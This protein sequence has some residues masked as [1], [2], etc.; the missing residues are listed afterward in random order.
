MSTKGMKRDVPEQLAGLLEPIDSIHPCPRNPRTGHAVEAIARSIRDFGWHAP[1]VARADG[2]I[3]IG[4]GRLEAA[5][6]LGLSS[7][8]VLRVDDTKA[9]AIARMV[10]DNRLTELSGWDVAE[11][12]ALIGDSPDLAAFSA[13][14]DLESIL[15]GLPDVG[16][17]GD[18]DDGSCVD[19]EPQVSIA[20]ELCEK[21]GV[22]T[23]QMWALGEHRIVCGDC[24]DASVVAQ[25]MAG[26]VADLVVT[27]PPY[28]VSYADK[29][30]FLNSIDEGN[31][32]QTK[33]EGDHKTPDEMLSFW[34]DVWKTTKPH[35]ADHCSYYMTGPQGGDLLLLLL[36]SLREAGWTLKHMLIWAKNNHVLGR[37]D[38]NYKHEPIL[39]GWMKKHRWYGDGSQTSLWEV[40]RPNVAKE[41]PTMKPVALF[42]CAVANSSA[43]GDLVFEPFS[44]SGTTIIACEQ[45]GRKC[46]A[47]EISPGY[48]AVAIQRWADATGGEPRLLD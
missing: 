26:G 13:D 38:Y 43:P 18:G 32:V 19:A 28:G 1:I 31:R 14:L 45:L 39:Y 35:L 47:I 6:L 12:E 11:L 40:P 33:I 46:R 10:A 25:V 7:V 23:G 37:C 34:T 48:V 22:K 16:D 21:W 24:T 30:K 42:A 2:E 3:I 29:N 36:L 9:Q 27:D 15:A 17:G 41:H 44:G 8:P 4:H 20:D 5:K